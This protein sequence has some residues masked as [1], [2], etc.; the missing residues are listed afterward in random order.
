MTNI[1]EIRIRRAQFED[2]P[3][4]AEFNR[5]LARETEGRELDLETVRAG[6]RAVL[7]RPSRGKYFV[8]ESGSEVVGQVLCTHEWSDW[9]NGDLWWLQSVYVHAEYRQH[10]VFR[11]LWEHVLQA[12]EAAPEVVGL[13]L[14]VEQ[15]NQTAIASYQR[16][17]WESAGYLVLERMLQR[18]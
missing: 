9:R 4:L 11:R 16:L 5:R 14:Y 18:S 15:G 8:A 3:T 10:G 17:G 6:V 1:A 12:A 2:W 7:Q 13:R